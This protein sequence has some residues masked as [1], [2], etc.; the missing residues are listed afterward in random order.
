MKILGIETSCDECSVA[1]VENGKSILSN[2]VA[3]Q[4]EFHK[5]FY[6]VVPEIASRKHVEWILPVMQR[7][8]GQAGVS[9]AQLDGVAATYRPG[10][11]GSLLVGLS[12]AKGLA[13]AAGKPL[14]AV[15]HIQA[16]LFAPRLVA[17]IAPPYI[18]LIV[19]GGHTLIARVET[20]GSFEVMGTTIDD[21]C[22]EA[23]DKVAKHYDFGYPGG[24]AI[25]KL[26][27]KGDPRAFDFPKPSL[28]KGDHTYDVSYS[29]LKTAAVN[30]LDQ[31][32]NRDYEKSPENIS[33]SFQKAAVDFIA[34][35]AILAA[36][37]TGIRL[38]VAGGGV[39]ANRY[40]RRR[41]TETDGMQAIFPPISLCTDNGAMI[42]GLA[43]HMLEQGQ[44]AGFDVNA[45]ARVPSFRRTYP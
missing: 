34:D 26:A 38:I 13:L 20:F 9:L 29:G 17:E 24:V 25:E 5:P 10:L 41:L 42:A 3:T 6:G 44:T 12:F 33:A 43:C 35:K 37:D 1:V 14:I 11:I 28:H 4:I 23:L 40:L 45:E 22:G 31:F 18:G 36:R 19:S 7:A 21:A 32:W 2:I 15:D 39:S 16:H 30:Q 27:E 8:L